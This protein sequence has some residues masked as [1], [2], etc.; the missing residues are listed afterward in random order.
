MQLNSHPYLTRVQKQYAKSQMLILSLVLKA[1][2]LDHDG[3]INFNQTA[4]KKLL[5]IV[6]DQLKKLDPGQNYFTKQHTLHAV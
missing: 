5:T 3:Y 1:W 2:D 4:D 6:D